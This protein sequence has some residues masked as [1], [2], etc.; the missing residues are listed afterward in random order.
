[1]QVSEEQQDIINSK[2]NTIVVSNP[3]TGKTTTL[4][5]KVIEL[6][7]DGASPESILCITFTDKAK[8][9]M[10]DAIYDAGRGI[11]SDED[12]MRINIHTFH[13]F[14][15]NYLADAGLIHD[16][17][18]E[19]NLMR[20]SILNSLEKNH[21]TTYDKDYLISNIVPKMENAIRYTKSF[22]I[23]PDEIDVTK[24]R[25]ILGEI[26]EE[27]SSYSLDEMNVFLE[28][29]ILAYREYEESKGDSVDYTDVL[30]T[31]IE[32]FRGDRFDHVLVDEMQ[33][34]NRIE[35]DIVRLVAKSMFL[36]GDAKQA[37][38]G[39]QGGSV[40]NFE[41]F[42]DTCERKLLS[43]SRRSV[44]QI[45]DY[46]REYFLGRTENPNEVKKE[47]EAFTSHQ[48]G[49]VPRIIS[50]NATLSRIL[51][52]IRANPDKKVGVITSTN[53][54][55][56]EISKFLDANGVTYSSTSSQATGQYA[57]DEIRCFIR[58]LLSPN[59]KDK[60]LATFT[61][62]SPHTLQEA[63]AFSNSLKADNHAGFASIKSWGTEMHRTD[64]D[65]IYGKTILPVCVSKGFEWFAT[66]V[67]VKNEIDQYMALGSPT[68][69]GLLDFM[70]IGE[71]SYMEQESKSNVTLT[72]IHKAK[73]REFDVVVYVPG[74]SPK[75]SFV[76]RIT[77][78]ILL[79]SGIDV[80][81]E[82]EEESLR[83]DFVAFTR[84]KE[85]LVII[86]KDKDA[87]R[88]HLQ[89]LSEFEADDST[90][91]KAAIQ[92]DHRLTEAYSMFVAGRH[93]DSKRLL[94]AEEDWIARLIRDYFKNIERLSYY[95]INTKPY[96]FL[97]RNIISMPSRNFAMEFGSDVHAA[98]QQIL[99]G[100]ANINEYTGDVKKSAQNI[101]D[102]INDLKDTY[103]EMEVDSVESRM[104]VRL[105]S[106]TDGDNKI[107]FTGKLDTVF[108]HGDRYLIVDYKTDKRTK[109]KS[110]HRKQLAAYRRM[111]SVSEDIPEEQ[112]DTCIIFPAL[113]GGINTGKMELEIDK[114]TKDA[115]PRFEE[116]LKKVLY[117][118]NDP[119]AFINELLEVD[120]DE[121]LFL[122][123]R[124]KLAKFNGSDA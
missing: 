84:A 61:V 29:F 21:T 13:S 12:L 41:K 3:G 48:T 11:F 124:E 66:A 42:H 73:G 1:M 103:G 87:K 31:F 104:E 93:S 95:V 50:T 120:S 116:D 18:I 123:V 58:G 107:R 97:K 117:W 71:E 27:S 63:F 90:D 52:I 91:V 10:F 28:H 55:I 94:D 102:A 109:N 20:F 36:V 15:Y 114:S 57:K 45:L 68:L 88:Y 82:L 77:Q 49:M 19:N 106:M 8:K 76:D 25:S 86:A 83:R 35:A 34:M 4:S 59:I 81:T 37:I 75:S 98:M 7:K 38:F 74:K 16:N 101:L 56:I 112:I 24:A 122:A 40:K 30:L 32:K 99:T 85:Q 118:K 43:T 62:F 111:L 54:R 60:V 69:D 119:Q 51:D 70:A 26:Y 89:D 64:L 105:N 79:A 44:H 5:L 53:S 2:N 6:L 110:N 121:P 65:M 22:G 33:D 100:K 67:S 17:I 9:A 80:R 47:L 46:S 96:E 78:S 14:T 108:R 113:R 39:F 72:T 115:Y 92:S 23:I